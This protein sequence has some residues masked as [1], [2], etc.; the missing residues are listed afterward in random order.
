MERATVVT[1]SL[2]VEEQRDHYLEAASLEAGLDE[3]KSAPTNV[4]RVELLVRRPQIDHRESVDSA[5][6]SSAEG[7]VG[8]NWKV[9]GS[10]SSP[11][12]K[13][14][15]AKQ[16]TVMNNRLAR[17]VAGG[18]DRRYLAGDQI[19]VDLDISKENLPA[20]TRL[21]IGTAVVEVSEEPHLGCKKFEARFGKAAMR[22]VNSPVGRELRLRGL[23]A[24]VV[25]DGTVQV[26]DEVRKLA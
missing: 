3:V 18:D 5:D 21:A 26:G 13:S 12:G 16:L 1:A 8:D 15:P 17:L 2:Q 24:R 6:V 11:D 25:V 19:Y 9:K 7:M 23:N 22:F 14:V 20:G 4:G 10:S